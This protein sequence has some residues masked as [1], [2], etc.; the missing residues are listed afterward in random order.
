MFFYKRLDHTD[1]VTFTVDISS[2]TELRMASKVIAL[3]Q[4]QGTCLCL[5]PNNRLQASLCSCNATGPF[6]APPSFLILRI[7]VYDTR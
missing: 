7:N 6:S 2:A 1:H 3:V 5:A 4:S